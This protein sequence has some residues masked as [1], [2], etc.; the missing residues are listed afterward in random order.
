LVRCG[1]DVRSFS[2]FSLAVVCDLRS[3]QS[4]KSINY[5]SFS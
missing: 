5:L 3:N 1:R 4:N 2:H